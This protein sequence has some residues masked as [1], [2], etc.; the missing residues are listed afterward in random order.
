MGGKYQNSH[1]KYLFQNPIL[2]E[3]VSQYFE[4]TQDTLND[5]INLQ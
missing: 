3:Y 1:T 4:E 2:E 5:N